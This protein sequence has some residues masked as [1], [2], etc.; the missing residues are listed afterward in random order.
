MDIYAGEGAKVNTNNLTI[1]SSDP[2]VMRAA[3]DA[4]C[5]KTKNRKPIIVGPGES[6]V[7]NNLVINGE[8]MTKEE[9]LDAIDLFNKE[10]TE[11]ESSDAIE[12]EQL[13]RIEETPKK[14]RTKKA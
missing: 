4:F 6:V 7:A 11:E 9:Q 2:A 8:T 13:K 10:T 3:L 1:T 5:K 12:K 14:K